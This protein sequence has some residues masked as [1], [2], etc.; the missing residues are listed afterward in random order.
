[1]NR[2]ITDEFEKYL[3]D[4]RSVSQNTILS[5]KRDIARFS[6]FIE[7]DGIDIISATRNHI[8]TYILS[9]QD[10]G[11]ANTS[12]MRTIASLKSLYGFLFSNNAISKNPAADVVPPK[13]EQ[14]S[15]QFLSRDEIETLLETPDISSARGLRDKAIFE[16]MYASGLKVSELISLSVSDIDTTLGYIR[17]SKG[18]DI[19][20]V[21]LGKPAVNAAKSY[22]GVA[23]PM[24]AKEDETALFVSCS[25]GTAMSRQGLWKL[26]KEYA[27]KAGIRKSITPHTLRHSFAVHLMENGADLIS[28]QEMLGHKDASTTQMYAKMFHGRLREVYN[29]THPRA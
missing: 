10:E 24:M 17:C 18:N 22:I 1:M 29:K 6:S 26:I 25:G 5:Y 9:M 20:I 21:P 2:L 8:L 19:R 11:R 3:Q 7:K 13:K 14:K 28:I 4:K 16:I 12:V 23:R 27:A 15:P